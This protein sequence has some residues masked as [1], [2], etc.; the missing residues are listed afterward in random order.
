MPHV[1]PPALADQIGVGNHEAWY[2]WTAL[3]HRYPM[4]QSNF[5]AVSAARARPPFWYTFISGGVHWTMLS[6][7]HDYSQGSEQHA[8]ADAA[9]G[10]VDRQLTAW[11]VVAFHRPMYC[12]DA[13]GYAAHSPG[14]ALQ[15]ALEGLLL[16]HA[17]DLV[18]SGHEHG[19]ERIHPNVGGNVTAMPTPS[20]SG[21]PAYVRPGAP[22][23]LM[24][25]HGGAVQD[26]SWVEPPPPWSAVR[27]SSGCAHRG[28]TADCGIKA[29]AFGYLDTYGWM[30]A[31]FV[32]RT[33]GFLHTQMVGGDRLRDAFWLVRDDAHKPAHRTYGV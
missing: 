17:V 24:V 33:H 10:A 13:H 1:R 27:F 9:L 18:V 4:A 28:S 8:F 30:H 14:G 29:R 2:N 6:S 16:R 7:E 12:S 32:N 25:G 15:R 26:W 3:T 22:V 11:S 5:P 19:Y 31:E 21:E 23:Y 20:A